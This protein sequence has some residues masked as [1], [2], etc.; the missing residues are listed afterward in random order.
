MTTMET[1]LGIGLETGVGSGAGAAGSSDDA[2]MQEVLELRAAVASIRSVC[3]AA[4]RGDLEQ[5]VGPLGEDADLRATREAL[6]TLLD[7]TDAYVRESSASLQYAS[8]A[9]F[10]R[11]FITR[12]ML[13]SFSAGA[14]VIN[15]AIGAMAATHQ[16]LV[17]ERASRTRLAD[18]FES[19]VLGLADQVAAAAVEMESAARTLS[20][21]AESTATRAVQV[22]ENS[23]AASDA[24]TGAAA[25][26]EELAATVRAIDE[27]VAE[28]DRTGTLA[29][30]EAD[31]VAATA[32]NLASASQEI[33]AILG[34]ISQVANQTRLL[35]LNATIEAARAGEAGKG[36]AVVAAE[37]KSLAS[38]T[39]EATE[40][41]EQQVG[42]M[43][44]ASGDVLGAIESI[45]SAVRSMGSSIGDIAQ[46]VNGQRDAAAELS[47]STTQ[48]ANAVS[49]VST[50]IGAIGTATEAT[51]AGAGEMT[52]AALELARLSSDLRTHVID[53]LQQIR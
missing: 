4:A 16:G 42:A 28:S 27:Q 49:E 6:N 52:S 19:A 37:V 45:G 38:Q 39:A 20:G 1:G 15:T 47:R 13:G 32:R 24:V 44:S 3:Q 41:I 10:Y 29:V 12:G 7:L 51:S 22:Q 8:E 11:H 50:D 46:S 9:K 53:F 34:L 40:Q 25:A 31:Q 2:L 35:A 18:G 48:A 43:Q 5:R 23:L 21:S 33:G 26:V 14:R 30:R 36:F 17:D